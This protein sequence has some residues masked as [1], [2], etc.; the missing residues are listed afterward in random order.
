MAVYK[1]LVT[2]MPNVISG[3]EQTATEEDKFMRSPKTGSTTMQILRQ[4]QIPSS[5]TLGVSHL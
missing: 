2:P 1:F 3:P 4:E 5:E